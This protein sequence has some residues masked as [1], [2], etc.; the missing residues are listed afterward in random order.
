MLLGVDSQRFDRRQASN[1]ALEPGLT[2]LY[3]QL[4]R[5]PTPTGGAQAP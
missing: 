2:A 5:Q 4:S 1:I 3:K